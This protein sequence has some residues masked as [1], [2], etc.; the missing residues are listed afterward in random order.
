MAWWFRNYGGSRYNIVQKK[1]VLKIV[2]KQQHIRAIGRPGKPWKTMEAR[3]FQEA[4]HIFSLVTSKTQPDENSAQHESKDTFSQFSVT[5]ASTMRCIQVHI[6]N[7]FPQGNMG[8][9]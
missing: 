6:C 1:E 9:F 2:L 3:H 4:L 7:D 8:L 5:L